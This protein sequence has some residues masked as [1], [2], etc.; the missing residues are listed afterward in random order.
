MG[1]GLSPPLK[2]IMPRS[3]LR[4]YIYFIRLITKPTN[5]CRM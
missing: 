3:M 1:F 5:G 4:V 2:E